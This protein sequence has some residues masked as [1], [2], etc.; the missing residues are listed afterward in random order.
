MTAADLDRAALLLAVCADPADDVARLVFADWCD[1]NGQPERA[2]FIRVQLEVARRPLACLKRPQATAGAVPLSQC[3]IVCDVRRRERELW[4][5]TNEDGAFLIGRP[6]RLALDVPDYI[7]QNAMAGSRGANLVLWRRGFADEVRCPLAAWL[8]HGPRLVREHPITSVRATDREP[9]LQADR[10][11]SVWWL[12][13]GGATASL[14][15]RAIFDA[16]SGFLE[17]F[18]GW[19]GYVG[20]DDAHA[21]LSLALVAWSRREAGLPPLP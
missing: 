21:A 18:C 15:P 8:E 19:K 1:E 4:E 14:L 7:G 6:D 11:L 3:C 10:F 2:E 9:E 12:A 20:G 5:L 17:G 13:N 16:L